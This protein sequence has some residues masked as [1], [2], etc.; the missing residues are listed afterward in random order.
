MQTIPELETA[1]I[2]AAHASIDPVFRDSPQYVHE[3]L[4]ERVGVPVIVKIET[5]NPIRSFKGRG[6]WV[7]VAALAAEGAIGP[8]R[9]IVCASA[10]NFGQGVAYAAR[11]LGVPALVFASRRANRAKIARMRALGAE[12]VEVPVY[13]WEPP[14]DIGPLDRLT[15]A[16]LAGGVEVVAFTSAPAAA[17]LLRRADERGVLDDLL[18]RLRGPVLA[19]CVGPVT[20]APLEALDVPTVQPH[21]S[22]LG[23]MVR[24]L[25]AEMPARARSLPVAGHWLELR[26][27]AVLV[28]GDLRVLPPNGMTLLQSLARRP[29]RVVPRSELLAALPGRGN[30]EHAVE[31]A[32]AR[33]R[34]ALGNPKLVQTVVKRGYRLALD[35]AAGPVPVGG[36]CLHGDAV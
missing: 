7:A 30:D 19:L 21:R 8:D 18:L 14:A 35:P 4:S 6:T 13:R 2:R 23:A 11:A 15:D 9:A 3:G 31:T 34:A 12:V 29:G 16:V 25:E 5:A 33:L 1:A 24:R 17:S 26:G 10:G 32:I 20:A 22:R 28:D 36:H 27:H